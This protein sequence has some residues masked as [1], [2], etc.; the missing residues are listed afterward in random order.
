MA[1]GLVDISVQI[2]HRTERAVLVSGDGNKD[3]TVWIPLSQC[4][5][6]DGPRGTATITM[7]EWLAIDKRLI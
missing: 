2:H 6:E 5:V 7:P 3:R 4:E 1:S